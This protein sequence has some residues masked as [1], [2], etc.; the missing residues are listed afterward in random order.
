MFQK[1]L[2]DSLAKEVTLK[3]AIPREVVDGE[4]RV[5]LSPS[6][7]Q[8]LTQLGCTILFEKNAGLAAGFVDDSY[9]N[10]EVYHDMQMLYHD[11]DVIL[12]V[13]PPL[14]QEIAHYKKNTI[15]ISFLYPIR[16]NCFAMLCDLNVT[17]FAMENIPRISRAQTMDALSS[18]ATVS[19][20]KSVMIAANMANRF[21]PML[22]TASG[23]IKP[24]QVLVIGAGVAGLQ[25]IA[26]ARRL[27]AVVHAYDI[28]AAARE[29]VESLG[30]KMIHV[31][32]QAETVGGYAR[33]LHDH[34]KIQQ[35][36]V[37][38]QALK[39]ADIIVCT[40]LLPGKPAPKIIKQEMVEEMLSGSLIIDMAADTGGNCELTQPNKIIQHQHVTIYGPTNIPSLLARDASHMYSKNV[41]NFLKLLIKDRQIDINWQDEILAKSVVTHAGEI[42]HAP[43]R[44][45]VEG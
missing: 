29:Q 31:D 21:F 35:Q 40:A 16:T 5:A 7:A 34:E 25:A 28:R 26:T 8:E 27:G 43:I 11:A 13:Q 2:S 3:I 22:T 37:L 19:G 24:A 39:S 4:K 14:E 38:K 1:Q 10:V 20:Y 33:E 45:L 42:K 12:K 41:F 36:Q 9:Q 32:L 30:A 17:S 18:Q 23:T 44:E 15:L 6:M